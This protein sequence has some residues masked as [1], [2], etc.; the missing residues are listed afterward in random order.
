[1]EIKTLNL[2]AINILYFEKKMSMCGLSRVVIFVV[3]FDTSP[4][5]SSQSSLSPVAVNGN[6]LISTGVLRRSKRLA[7]KK[8]CR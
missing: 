3:H 2:V 1:M 6:H 4:E 7:S 5:G 8:V